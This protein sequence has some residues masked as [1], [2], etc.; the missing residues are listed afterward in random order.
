ML[1]GAALA[2][3]P[4]AAVPEDEA[5]PAPAAEPRMELVGLRARSHAAVLERVTLAARLRPLVVALEVP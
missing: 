4:L 5:P 2:E 3:L 1:A